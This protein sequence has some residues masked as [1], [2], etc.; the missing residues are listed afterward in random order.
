MN[1]ELQRAD[2]LRLPR[3]L[4]VFIWAVFDAHRRLQSGKALRPFDSAYSG[5]TNFTS[6]RV[7]PRRHC[8]LE[9]VRNAYQLN[10]CLCF[11]RYRRS[12]LPGG[13]ATW[14]RLRL[15][16]ARFRN[17]LAQSGYGLVRN[18]LGPQT[19]VG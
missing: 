3:G 15:D 7:H 5:P 8:K 2:W 17:T 18:R 10:L 19:F 6:V 14:L 13:A 4:G 12:A 11:E 9:L 16:G 1:L